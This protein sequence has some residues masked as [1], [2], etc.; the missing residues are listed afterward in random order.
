MRAVTKYAAFTCGNAVGL[1][2]TVVRDIQTCLF[3]TMFLWIN[4]PQVANEAL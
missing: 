3:R 2:H 4:I 1:E